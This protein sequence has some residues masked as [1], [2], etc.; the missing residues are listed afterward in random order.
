MKGSEKQIEWALKIRE[1]RIKEI[2][3]IMLDKNHEDHDYYHEL[4]NITLQ[5]FKN[6]DNSYFWIDT[7]KYRDA[8]EVLSQ[9]FDNK[10]FKKQG[11]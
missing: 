4:C 6:Y 9:Y 1:E 5:E 11:K 10:R 3:N 8:T 2:E 7:R